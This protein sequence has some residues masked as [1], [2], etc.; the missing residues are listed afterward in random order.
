[1]DLPRPI[2]M[3][4]E[5]DGL[6]TG[7]AL[8]GRLL[9]AG[10][11][12]TPE[13][14]LNLG[15]TASEFARPL[16]SLSSEPI[17]LKGHSRCQKVKSPLRPKRVHFQEPDII[18][19]P[20][21]KDETRQMHYRAQPSEEDLLEES[22]KLL[23]RTANCDVAVVGGGVIGTSVALHLAALGRRDIVVFEP[24]AKY[25]YASAPRSAG[26]L[27]QQFSLPV[28]VELSLYGVDFLKRGLERLCEGID[29]DTDVQFKAISKRARKGNGVNN[30]ALPAMSQS[31]SP[32]EL[33]P[34]SP[35]E[36]GVL[37]MERQPELV[38]VSG[39]PGVDHDLLDR[40]YN[41]LRSQ[42]MGTL[43]LAAQELDE[44]ELIA[45]WYKSGWKEPRKRPGSSN[46]LV[47]LAPAGER[48]RKLL[49]EGFISLAREERL[50][51]RWVVKL[52]QE[53][54]D[55]APVL[56]K[57]QG[58]LGPDREANLLV[59]R[60][61]DLVDFLL[62]RKVAEFPL[63]QRASHGRLAWAGKDRVDYGGG[64]AQLSIKARGNTW[65]IRL[66]AIVDRCVNYTVIQ[67][68]TEIFIKF[69]F[70][71]LRSGVWAD[72]DPVGQVVKGLSGYRGKE[73]RVAVAVLERYVVSQWQSGMMEITFF[74]WWILIMIYSSW[75]LDDALHVVPDTLGMKASTGSSGKLKSRGRGKGRGSQRRRSRCQEKIGWGTAGQRLP[76]RWTIMKELE[77]VVIA[78]TFE[79]LENG[80]LLLATPDGEAALRENNAV[81]H[82]AGAGW[83]RLLDP[84]ELNSRFPWLST[85]GVALGSF[86]ERN[87][88]YFDPW[89]LLQAMR[90]AAMAKGVRFVETAVTA[91]RMAPDKSI[92]AVQLADGTDATA[93]TVVNAAGAWGGKVVAMCRE[94]TPLPVVPRKRCIFL[95]H[96]G[97]EV[98]SDGLHPRPPE[99]TPLTID[100]SGVYFRSEGS[101]NRFLCG[102]S[103]KPEAD[104]DCDADALLDVDYD[105]FEDVIWPALAERAP[106]F[107]AIKLESSWAGLYEYNTLDQN[108]VVGWH[109][110]VPNMLVA[111]GFSGH[112]LQQAPGVGRAVAELLSLGGYDSID[113][114]VLGYDRILR[115]EPVF[116]RG[117]Y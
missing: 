47:V 72:G 93:K 113:L 12:L 106:A 57:L 36:E 50:Q 51:E 63:E 43:E 81:Q 58:S 108:G 49:D 27:R 62:S 100:A 68:T 69:V 114:S 76:S 40:A 87:E 8:L 109:P 44:C 42:G 48:N 117:I 74:A 34:S 4:S 37:E 101:R 65:D 78:Q 10:S 31:Q 9:L 52:K 29:V 94:V 80:Y 14:L 26:G 45:R 92:A 60:P 79:M 95:F 98:A 3:D 70:G 21:W 111:C 23:L 24:D 1:M 115:N 91:M 67:L 11:A 61:A 90:K 2:V 54:K 59:G 85:E 39:T 35:T 38:P 25:T 32:T 89:A 86:G 75:R 97:V 16:A 22:V 46:A 104:L 5:G 18:E 20:S 107:E 105:L 77:R 82:S 19:V 7:R 71:T 53:L 6:K 83:I 66:K 55:I 30:P 15:W 84:S 64:E 103:P 28:N 99:N 96:A 73:T 110:D 112:G 13:G 17:D 116:E 102:V 41:H 56:A 33:V 88:G